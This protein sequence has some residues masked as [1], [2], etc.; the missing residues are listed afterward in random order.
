MTERMKKA[1]ADLKAD[2]EKG[3]CTLCPRCGRDTMDPVLHRN[4]LSRQA[5]IEI[6]SSCGAEEAI[7]SF[8]NKQEGRFV[9]VS[10]QL[11]KHVHSC[12]Y[13]SFFN[14][15]NTVPNL[16]PPCWHTPSRA[17]IPMD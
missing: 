8:M 14:S 16:L 15:S 17:S 10:T 2:Q 11:A 1:L 9:R 13:V 3:N 5:D 7:L 12:L 6:C 4:A